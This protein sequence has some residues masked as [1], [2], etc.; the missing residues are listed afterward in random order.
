MAVCPLD[1][2]FL[3]KFSSRRTPCHRAADMGGMFIQ[4]ASSCKS[5]H[6]SVLP[7]GTNRRGISKAAHGAALLSE[8]SS[9]EEPGCSELL[10]LAVCSFR[11]IASVLRRMESRFTAH[12]CRG[13]QPYRSTRNSFPHSPKERAVF[14][15][16]SDSSSDPRRRANAPVNTYSALSKRN[17]APQHFWDGLMTGRNLSPHSQGSWAGQ[18][19]EAVTS[20]RNSHG[21]SAVMPG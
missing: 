1:C 6:R 7:P 12:Y 5:C 17:L 9:T 20:A 21:S 4:S 13:A 16:L 2:S 18:H 19:A 3:A 8:L 10:R 15:S 14:K 11:T